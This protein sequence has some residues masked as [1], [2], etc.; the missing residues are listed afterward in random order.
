MVEEVK[1]RPL[2]A[3]LIDTEGRMIPG[4]EEMNFNPYYDYNDRF[5]S[6]TVP[7]S[8]KEY[9]D[10]DEQPE[11][12][13]DT[14]ERKVLM[15]PVIDDFIEYSEDLIKIYDRKGKYGAGDFHQ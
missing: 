11:G 7:S 8:E 12:I 1:D 5:L 9:D 6:F 2:Y 10:Y 4:T 3:H 14:K 13:Y 15:E